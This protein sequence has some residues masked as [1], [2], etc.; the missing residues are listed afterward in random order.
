[1]MFVGMEVISYSNM[2]LSDRYPNPRY[3]L[4]QRQSAEIHIGCC[5]LVALRGIFNRTA[6][7]Y[8]PKAMMMTMMMMT[9]MI[10]MMMM[11]LMMTLTFH[12]VAIPSKICKKAGSVLDPYG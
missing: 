6:V 7:R 3:S 1:M 9:I 2:L 12:P 10:M 5:I 4:L 11:T 8:C